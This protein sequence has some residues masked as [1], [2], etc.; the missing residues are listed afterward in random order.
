MVTVWLL[1]VFSTKSLPSIYFK[2]ASKGTVK[3]NVLRK[4]EKASVKVNGLKLDEEYMRRCQDLALYPE[5]LHM[6]TRNLTCLRSK[7]DFGKVAVGNKL[8][9]I[10][11]EKEK[12]TKV[13]EDIWQKVKSV[14]SVFDYALLLSAI[15]K[16]TKSLA[17]VKKERQEKKLVELWLKKNRHLPNCLTNLSDRKLSVEEEAS[18]MNGL[19]FG[20][21]PKSLN[22]L[23]L[24]AM[25]EKKANFCAWKQGITTDLKFRDDVKLAIGIFSNAARNLCRS[26][27]NVRLHKTLNRLSKD[28]KIR[29]CRL[30]KGNGVC[31]MN[32]ID[33]FKKLNKIVLD[34]TKF[35]EVQF[36]FTKESLAN[37]ARAPWI[38]AESSIKYYLNTYVKKVV[39]NSTYKRLLPTGSVPGK[40]YGLAKVHKTGCPL[41]PVNCMIGTPEYETAKFVDDLI[42][43]Y[44]PK[45]Y[46]VNSTNQFIEKLKSLDC[47]KGDICVSFD[48][49]SL[50]TNV[51]RQYTIEKIRN[52]F[53]E[54]HGGTVMERTNEDG[55][56][57]SIC[58]GILA[59][60]LAK[61]TK[62][63]FI[64]NGKLYTQVDGVQM[65]S[66]L[67][68]TL[69]NWFLG[70]IER[71]IFKDKKTWH[72]KFYTRY[73]DDV[74]AVFKN[75]DD[76]LKFLD[77]LNSQ[78]E[79]LEFTVEYAKDTLPFLDVEV[80]LGENNIKTW[81]HRKPTDTG[82]LLN[83]NSVAPPS[84]K[85]G[86]IKCLL[87]RAKSVCSSPSLLSEEVDKISKLFKKNGYPEWF[88]NKEKENFMNGTN[89]KPQKEPDSKDWYCALTLPY[90]GSDSVKLARR[91]KSIFSETFGVVVK[92]SY[93]NCTVGDY[94]GLKDKTPKLFSSNVVY[95]FQC[96]EDETVAYIGTTSRQLW[97]RIKEHLSPRFDSA[98][99]SHVAICKGCQ[100]QPSLVPRF[101]LLKV[102]REKKEAEIIEPRQ[103]SECKPIL[104]KQILTNG[105]SF[106]LQIFK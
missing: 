102:C 93:R 36:D 99:Q 73:V 16:H 55:K 37:C 69:A 25:L 41:R 87:T 12:A 20:I 23:Q 85:T 43:P 10:K 17:D 27:S 62:G 34:D 5:F 90:I 94:F 57:A 89:N 60:M 6:K 78:H 48:V 1:R 19:K 82:V 56:T 49:K 98:V 81:L 31:L 40:L 75:S 105:K 101:S 63:H 67:G 53:D 66:P 15:S 64:Y 86:L 45:D 47:A 68:P 21:L 79:N 50:F 24:K 44:I 65:G 7:N 70:D 106:L 46:T 42:K 54:T 76:V 9:E 33:Y 39:D 59:K 72:P 18:L 2:I 4:L 71:S 80:S 8:K 104:N 26:R 88:F 91:L 103:I 83:Y 58:S 35:Q 97:V 77:L 30:D 13:L 14:I 61:C 74:F 84:W 96:F 100:N 22:E 32:S 11:K 38:K 95:K 51:P 92:I 29:I 3:V 52:Y 28:D